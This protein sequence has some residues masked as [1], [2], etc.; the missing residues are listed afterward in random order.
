MQP[1]EFERIDLI[2]LAHNNNDGS[3]N[4]TVTKYRL[5][6]QSM[7]NNSSLSVYAELTS[8]HTKTKVF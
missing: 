1:N 5:N 4:N 3:N 2:S 7:K 8:I 6:E